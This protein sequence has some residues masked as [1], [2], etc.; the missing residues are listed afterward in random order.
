MFCLFFTEP[1]KFFVLPVDS[2]RVG[3]NGVFDVVQLQQDA[4][5]DELVLGE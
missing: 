3:L 4:F 1:S 2:M 5:E